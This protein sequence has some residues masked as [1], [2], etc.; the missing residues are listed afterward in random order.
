[1]Y[2]HCMKKIPFGLIF[3][4]IN[5]LFVFL[6]LYQK[7]K[8][9]ALSYEGQE[10]EQQLQQEQDETLALNHELMELKNPKRIYQIATN[11]LGMVPVQLSQIER[12]AAYDS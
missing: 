2:A 11:Q 6:L 1:M 8:I 10:L 4:I 7:N 12:L 5:V 9:V 3:I